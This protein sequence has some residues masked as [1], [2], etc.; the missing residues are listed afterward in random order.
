[1]NTQRL[2]PGSEF[3]KPPLPL[4]APLSRG[5]QHL[6]RN[7]KHPRG[8]SNLLVFFVSYCKRPFEKCLEIYVFILENLDNRERRK[9]KN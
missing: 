2:N 8:D 7:R 6:R 9:K 4:L 5:S 1:M 3:P